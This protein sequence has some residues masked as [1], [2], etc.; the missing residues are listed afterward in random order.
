MIMIEEKGIDRDEEKLC[1]IFQYLDAFCSHIP[2]SGSRS[3]IRTIDTPSSGN[4]SCT[5]AKYVCPVQY[6]YK[7]PS[8]HTGPELVE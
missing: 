2:C 7:Q 5:R 8:A 3:R 1:L 6:M 4:T